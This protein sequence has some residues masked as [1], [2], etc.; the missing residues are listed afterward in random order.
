MTD[1]TLHR[2][3]HIIFCNC[4]GERIS[5][6][7]LSALDTQLRKMPVSL[8]KAND[9]CGVVQKDKETVRRVLGANREHLVI[10]CYRRTMELLLEQI[11]VNNTGTQLH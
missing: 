6:D 5:T 1:K 2:K 3:R 8:T 9:L 10:G 4:S 11:P 7:L